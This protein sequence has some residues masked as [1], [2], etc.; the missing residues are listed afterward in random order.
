MINTILLGLI[1]ISL[2]ILIF[3][4][5]RYLSAINEIKQ[6][7]IMTD[8][9]VDESLYKI[10]DEY[11]DYIFNDY[12][13]LVFE[14]RDLDYINTEEEKKMIKDLLERIMGRMSNT[15]MSKMILL[16]NKDMIPDILAEKVTIKVTQY[17]L[18][19]NKPKNK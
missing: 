17:V 9:Q 6:F 8:A 14:L 3:I 1:V 7:K 18:E 19:Y 13:I 11:I 5:R 4:I 15:I 10:I 16:Y 2:Y 12:L